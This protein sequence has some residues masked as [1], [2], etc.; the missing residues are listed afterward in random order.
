MTDNDFKNI[1]DIQ[2]ILKLRVQDK[3]EDVQA[4]LE[5]LESSKKELVADI[6]D[7]KI[8]A[9]NRLSLPTLIVLKV[10]PKSF[11]ILAP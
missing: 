5:K 3:H 8:S 10:S 4:E 9:L 7:A 1:E 2:R 6:L 11:K